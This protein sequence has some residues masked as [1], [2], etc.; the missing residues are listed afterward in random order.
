MRCWDFLSPICSVTPSGPLRICC[1]LR[2]SLRRNS[3]PWSSPAVR[4]PSPAGNWNPCSGCCVAV[5]PSPPK[6]LIHVT[7]IWIRSCRLSGRFLFPILGKG[8]LGTARSVLPPRG[9]TGHLHSRIVLPSITL[10]SDGVRIISVTHYIPGI[11]SILRNPLESKT[12]IM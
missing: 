1:R 8:A 7:A 3:S 10:S 6:R 9:P 5:E 12:E 2:L 4:L 11:P